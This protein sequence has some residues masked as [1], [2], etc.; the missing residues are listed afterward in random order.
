MMPAMPQPSRNS[1]MTN[2]LGHGALIAA[3]MINATQKWTIVGVANAE[4]V[5]PVL[6]SSSSAISVTTTNMRP[7]SAPAE[8]PTIT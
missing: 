6:R 2:R 4:N 3:E 7:V 1:A 5:A 8:D